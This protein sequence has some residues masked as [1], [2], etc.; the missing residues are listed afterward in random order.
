M[1]NIYCNTPFNPLKPFPTALAPV[2][3]T[4]R[5]FSDADIIGEYEPEIKE[6]A[7]EQIDTRL[8]GQSAM[9]FI[10]DHRFD[11][12]PDKFPEWQMIVELHDDIVQL[13]GAGF[14]F[15]RLLEL[16]IRFWQET[17]MF[18]S[19]YDLV[20]DLIFQ[21]I[22]FIAEKAIKAIDDYEKTAHNKRQFKT[23]RPADASRV[24][25]PFLQYAVDKLGAFRAREALR[26]LFL[27]SPVPWEERLSPDWIDPYTGAID[28]EYFDIRLGKSS[29]DEEQLPEMV[30]DMLEDMGDKANTFLEDLK[31]QGLTI[32]EYWH[33]FLEAQ[34]NGYVP[35]SE[36]PVVFDDNEINKSYTFDYDVKVSRDVEAIRER[37]KEE[38]E[39]INR[40][41]AEAPGRVKQGTL[42]TLTSVQYKKRVR[43][44][45]WRMIHKGIMRTKQAKAFVRAMQKAAQRYRPADMLTVMFE[46]IQPFGLWEEDLRL[47]HLP[48]GITLL[49]WLDIHGD[50][51]FE[52]FVR[53]EANGIDYGHP[54]INWAVQ[55]EIIEPPESEEPS[56]EELDKFIEQSAKEQAEAYI[57]SAE[58]AVKYNNARAWGNIRGKFCKEMGIPY[59]AK[60]V[61]LR[62]NGA[63]NTPA[64]I[65]GEVDAAFFSSTANPVSVAWNRWR[66]ESDPSAYRAY[67]EARKN[68][69]SE[70]EARKAYQEAKANRNRIARLNRNGAVL[71]SGRAVNWHVLSLKLASGEIPMTKEDYKRL[72]ELLQTLAVNYKPLIDLINKCK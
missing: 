40:L 38:I 63:K 14:A 36:D 2:I 16:S 24:Y 19:P 46:F 71:Q 25:G 52:Q 33:N 56:D 30:A 72:G 15:K 29:K 45:A 35:A 13:Q 18:P 49:D 7:P 23:M 22:D 37:Y 68:G 28:V 70:A 20:E 5:V 54:V 34:R 64:F 39:A 11:R 4:A 50:E 55:E 57:R 65:K 58:L 44:S 8:Q 1:N 60:P 53:E 62:L 17:A 69:L 27:A 47:I 32:Q 41:I 66:K 26:V 9:E 31:K 3:S 59:R 10:E 48:G 51:F 12:W 21:A 42:I 6:L 43:R 67:V 61:S